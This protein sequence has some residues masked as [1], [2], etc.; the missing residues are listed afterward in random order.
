MNYTHTGIDIGAMP[1]NRLSILVNDE[2][3]KVPFDEA[4]YEK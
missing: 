1:L 4:A 3:G 2:L